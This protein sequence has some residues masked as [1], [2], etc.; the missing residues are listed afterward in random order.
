MSSVSLFAYVLAQQLIAKVENHRHNVNGERDGHA[1]H[2]LH[3]VVVLN[4][5]SPE[6]TVHRENEVAVGEFEL[7]NVCEWIGFSL[8][9]S[10]THTKDIRFTVQNSLLPSKARRRWTPCRWRS[11]GL[12]RDCRREACGCAPSPAGPPARRS[13]WSRARQQSIRLCDALPG[14]TSE[15][16]RQTKEFHGTTECSSSLNVKTVGYVNFVGIFWCNRK[17]PKICRKWAVDYVFHFWLLISSA[18]G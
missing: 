4:R 15:W 12:A 8:S 2:E 1:V 11:S 6:D 16:S 18:S 7:L 3:P 17:F 9:L 5:Q 10:S 14:S 13:E